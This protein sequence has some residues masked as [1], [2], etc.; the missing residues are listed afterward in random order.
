MENTMTELKARKYQIQSR[1]KDLDALM[2]IN[3]DA[4]DVITGEFKRIGRLKPQ[5]GDETAI[6]E[7]QAEYERITEQ[8]DTYD[9]E[10]SSLKK[11]LEAIETDMA[12]LESELAKSMEK[13]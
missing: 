11:Q 8:Y 7:Y 2:Q 13:Q 5:P 6:A 1:L 12:I 10:S 9:Y 4:Q 3:V